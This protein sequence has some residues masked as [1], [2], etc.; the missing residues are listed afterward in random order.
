MSMA[1]S[2]DYLT[3]NNPVR[4]HGWENSILALAFLASCMQNFLKHYDE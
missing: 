4:I 3:F 1:T 2:V